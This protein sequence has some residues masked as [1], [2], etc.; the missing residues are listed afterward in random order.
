MTTELANV[1]KANA[2]VE[3]SYRLGVMEQRIIL[4]CLAQL[5]KDDVITDETFY[6]VSA[7]DIGQLTETARGSRGQRHVR[8]GVTALARH[9]S[10]IGKS[11][12]HAQ[13]ACLHSG[14]S[15]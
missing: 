14:A 5:R 13:V 1:V 12:R 6:T 10:R 2:L 7:R 3:S 11:G 4:S 8:P 15:T 9:A